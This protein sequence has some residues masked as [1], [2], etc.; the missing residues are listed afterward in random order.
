MRKPVEG[1]LPD[2][3]P[4]ERP[5]FAGAYFAERVF[6]G[7]EEGGWWYN[8]YDHQASV[9]IPEGQDPMAVALALW[10]EFSH[11]DDGRSLGSVLSTGAVYVYWEESPKEHHDTNAQH[12]E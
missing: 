4:E 11:M 1:R 9:L 7:D 5:K 10:E 6:G 8:I 2:Y 12:Y 3:L